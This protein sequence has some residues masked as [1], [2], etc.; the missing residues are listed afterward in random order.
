[1]TEPQTPTVDYRLTTEGDFPIITE[2][3]TLLNDHFY[4]TGYRLPRPENVAQAWLESFQRTL[5]R[6]SQSYI[7][8]IDGRVAGFILC[9]V[10]RVPLYFGGVLVGELSDMWIVPEARRLGI[11]DK[12]VRLAIEWERQQGVHSIEIQVLLENEA[13]WRIFDRMGFKPEFRGARLV[14]DEY[15]DE[16]GA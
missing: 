4:K 6:F 9:R 1:M 11:G 7:A 3:Y 12:L 13:S 16:V 10:K 15:I 8:E 2:M 5:G 14:W